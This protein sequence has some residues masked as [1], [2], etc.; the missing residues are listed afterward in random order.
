MSS[1][2]E[3]RDTEDLKTPVYTN[4]APAHRTT[5]APVWYIRILHRPVCRCATNFG[6]E[7]RTGNI[8]RTD[9]HTK[10][11]TFMDKAFDRVARE[12]VRSLGGL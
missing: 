6:D 5:P 7:Y 3:L 4:T 10:W 9:V 2:A 8:D 12:V 1:V 11:V